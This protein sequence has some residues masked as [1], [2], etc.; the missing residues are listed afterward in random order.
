MYL[1]ESP[2]SCLCNITFG[3][4]MILKIIIVQACKVNKIKKITEIAAPPCRRD[5]KSYAL[6]V[7]HF[8]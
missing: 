3:F 7:Q 5:I 4:A 2:K 1:N 6:L 8:L